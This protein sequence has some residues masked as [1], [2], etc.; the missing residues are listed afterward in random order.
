[1]KIVALVPMRHHSV[2]VSG[3]NFRIFAGKPLFHHIVNTLLQCTSIMEIVIDTDSETI[4]EDVK[5]YFPS[6]RILKRPEHLR[7]D[8]IPMNEILL[9]DINT[10]KGDFFLQTHSTNPLLKPETIE[11]AISEFM[12]KCPQ[13]DSLF[14]VTEHHARFWD[15]VTRPINHNPHILLRTQDLPPIFEENSC[16]YI[17]NKDT[18]RSQLNRIG[19]RPLMFPI[20][21][22]ESWDIDE[23]SDFIIAE[24]L[25][26]LRESP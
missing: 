8:S 22:R 9:H 13:Y 7:A 6:V 24:Q 26:R 25:M 1:M 5:K 14:S 20:D 3:K 19:L 2:R 12:N 18:L 23:E 21:P 10:L 17:F 4:M 16:L 15:C 11:R